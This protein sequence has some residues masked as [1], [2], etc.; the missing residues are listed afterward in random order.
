MGH[1]LK[2]ITGFTIFYF[3]EYHNFQFPLLD[4]FNMFI[5]KLNT[6]GIGILVLFIKT[7]SKMYV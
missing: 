5:L 6:I 4:F 7:E 2:I 1:I 3:T